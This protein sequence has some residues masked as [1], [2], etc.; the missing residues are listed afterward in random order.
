M[1]NKRRYVLL[2]ALLTCFVSA[3]GKNKEHEI[4]VTKNESNVT[5]V[6]ITEEQLMERLEKVSLTTENWNDYFEDYEYTEHQVERDDSGEVLDEYDVTYQ[7]FGLKKNLTAV[8]NRITFRFSGMTEVY[9]DGSRCVYEA[10]KD[11]AVLYSK[12]GIVIQEIACDNKE[13]YEAKIVSNGRKANEDFLSGVQLF[14]EHECIEVVGEIML[15]DLPIENPND[16]VIFEFPDGT[17][18]TNAYLSYDML[19]Q[20]ATKK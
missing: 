15:Y 16:Y 10:G 7:G 6:S 5:V 9:E 14:E 17:S 19:S 13:Y 2:I 4:T 1:I 11:M 12:D 18:L 8:Y 20:Y 3:C